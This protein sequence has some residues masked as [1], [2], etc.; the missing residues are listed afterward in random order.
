[1]IPLVKTSLP[2]KNILMPAL[3]EVLYSG[4][5]AQGD[6]VEKFERK[7]EE[8]IGGGNTLSLNSGTA[9]LHI[10]LILA[11][12]KEGDEI[13]STALTAEPTNVVIKMMGAT[14]RWA[15]IDQNTGSICTKSVEKLI[16]SKTKA[17][18]FVDYAGILADINE[19]QRISKEYN[20]TVIEDAAHALGAKFKGK[21]VGDFFPLQYFLFKQLSI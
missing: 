8:F 13:I 3:E 12:I 20:I 19:L 1:M 5:I 21:R 17:I 15:D 6:I 2:E 11:N 9:A 7:F 14:I 4:Y 18:L 16:T 10:A